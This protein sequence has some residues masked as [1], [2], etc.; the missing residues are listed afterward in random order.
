MGEHGY[1][2][3]EYSGL[4]RSLAHLQISATGCLGRGSRN[5][6][7]KFMITFL[8]LYPLFFKRQ[9]GRRGC[10]VQYR[11]GENGSWDKIYLY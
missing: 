5:A 9:I 2:T 6:C 4:D 3:S 7:D 8:L 11:V 1:T 10:S